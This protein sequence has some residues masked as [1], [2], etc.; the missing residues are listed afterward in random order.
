MNSFAVSS[1]QVKR[2]E[3]NSILAEVKK[4]LP[5]QCSIYVNARRKKSTAVLK[6]AMDSVTQ[7]FS[8]FMDCVLRELPD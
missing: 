3:G 7:I 8:P 1:K 6:L 4:E 2:F 5:R